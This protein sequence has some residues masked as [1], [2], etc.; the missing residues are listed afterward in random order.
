MP[1]VFMRK[2]VEKSGFLCYHTACKRKEEIVMNLFKRIVSVA[3]G[4]CLF[5][6]AASAC[7]EDNSALYAER[8]AGLQT[9]AEAAEE[10]GEML[11]HP[12]D[13]TYI[14]ALRTEIVP[15]DELENAGYPAVNGSFSVSDENVL[16][17][18]EKGMITALREGN[19]ELTYTASDGK[20]GY[21]VTVSE[22][23]V[24]ILIRNYIYIANREY[25]A[26]AQTHLEK[27]NTY[28]KWYYGKKKEVG[29][30]SVFTIYC[31]NASGD[32][33]WRLKES[34]ATKRF[35]ALNLDESPTVLHMAEGEVGHQYDAFL[36]LGRFGA[37]PK[38]GYLVIYADLSKA[39]RTTH[40]ASVVDVEDRGNGVYAVTTVEGN[41]SN[42]VKRYC[43]LYDSNGDNHLIGADKKA[44]M[45]KLK[46]NMSE[47]PADEQTDPLVQYQL[48][49]DHWA[50]FGFC[51]TW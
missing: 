17:V 13:T 31:A 2:R 30:C 18:D 28:A 19:C 35:P 37:V 41:M 21:Q 38:P 12:G 48:H 51:E 26:T 46:K 32:A 44:K 33:V 4:V 50:V 6:I 47:L 39:Y 5:C 34:N 25:Y 43:Y 49:T 24:P 29:W 14:P 15:Y 10:S 16:A 23:T 22:E 36:K 40:I 7:G 27:Y 45:G 20:H 42:T 11:L 1:A 8:L 3:L 9:P